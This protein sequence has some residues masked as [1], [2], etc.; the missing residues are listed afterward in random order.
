MKRVTFRAEYA[1]PVHPIQAAIND[2]AA[3]KRV[4]L[5]YWSPTSDDTALVW[6]DADP[7]AVAK[8]LDSVDAVTGASLHLMS[9]R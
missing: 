6:F 2:V 5:L 3:I 8:V 9:G 1:E 7:A 4:D